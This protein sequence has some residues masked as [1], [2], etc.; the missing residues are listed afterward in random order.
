MSLLHDWVQN[1]LPDIPPRLNEEQDVCCKYFCKNSFSDAVTTVE[2]SKNSL[3]VCSE[4]A[5]TI[6]IFKE[7]V[8]RLANFRRIQV[9]EA[10]TTND[11]SITSIFELLRSKLDYQLSLSRKFELLD[12]LQ[13][14]T[15]QEDNISWLPAEYADI[16]QNQESIRREFKLREKA[17]GY[18]SGMLTDLYV[19]W[20]RL[21]GNVD[22]RKHLQQMQNA[23][24]SGNYELMIQMF[25]PVSQRK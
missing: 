11:D 25:F 16:L 22:N 13:E 4:C 10:V 20:G 17:L 3:I 19:D 24:L 2:Y 5:S 7:N 6:V 18:L 12:S 9:E 21:K 1:I 15:M 23:I 8:T 14:I